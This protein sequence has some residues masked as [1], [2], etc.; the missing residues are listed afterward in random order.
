MSTKTLH[1]DSFN[2]V[3]TRN[4]QKGARCLLGASAWEA[5]AR[6]PDN[7]GKFFLEFQPPS[8][9]HV[10]LP[11]TPLMSVLELGGW[12]LHGTLG[13]DVPA[14]DPRPHPDALT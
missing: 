12:K 10:Q 2:P 3:I 8:S 13:E 4:K 6:V 1:R 14:T 5:A 9:S 7:N 11:L